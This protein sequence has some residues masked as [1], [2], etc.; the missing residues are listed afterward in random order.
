MNRDILLRTSC[1]LPGLALV[2]AGHL[3]APAR[4]W[5]HENPP[6]PGLLL[7][8]AVGATPIHQGVWPAAT[9]QARAIVHGEP[10]TGTIGPAQA[11]LLNGATDWIEMAPSL[12][13][14]RPFL[15]AR[16]LTVSAWVQLNE[17]HVDGGILGFVQ[18]NGNAETG[19][20]LGYN[21]RSFTFSLA[22]AGADDGDGKLTRIAGQSAVAF[23]RWYYVAATY[24]GARMR[25]YVNGRLEGESD[26]QSGDIRY[27]TRGRLAW[28]A[29][30]DDNELHPMD[31]AILE[32]RVH[33]RVLGDEE[34]AAVARRQAGLLDW[35]ESINKILQFIVA[36]YLQAGGS[37][38]M[39]VMAETSQPAT[40]VVEYG[41]RQPL[42]QRVTNAEPQAIQTITLSGLKPFARYFYR[43]T[44]ADAQTNVARSDIL[45]FQTF[46]PPATTWAFGI[47]GDTQRNPDVTRRCAEGIFALRPNVVIHC[48]DVVDDGHAKQQWV[49]D[50]FAPSAALLAH[51]PVHPVIGNHEKNSHWYYDYFHLP[52]PEYY[53]TFM[54]GNAQFF[55][56][57]SN[58]D[59]GPGSEQYRWLDQALGRSRATWKFTAHHHPC[60]SSDENDYGDQWKAKAG[61]HFTY[62]D[63]NVQRL[64]PLYEKHG[65]DVAWAGHVHSYERT[66]PMLGLSINQKK[67]VRYIVT[68]GGGG[69]LEQAGPQRSWFTAHVA[70][71]YHYCFVAVQDRTIQFKAY[72]ADGRL[73]D[74]FELVKP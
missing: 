32:A 13:S 65:V 20:M 72:D 70:R 33:R 34:I 40:M 43:V 58:K 73:F 39:T 3:S 42:R 18:D 7:H 11:L 5:A 6:D 68:G 38:T 21:R 36:P 53:Y 55:M 12:E 41:E 22:S 52:A 10:V 69:P 24:D 62:G 31:G 27:P 2:L 23:D 54:I 57:D 60:F 26:A 29:Y 67:G 37:T 61:T 47:L 8:F 49:N 17:T 4:T 71:G 74:S 15:P 46:P 50:L 44:C 14:A 35:R 9:G 19:W 56:L 59:C 48:G 28:G 66:W 30:V 63:T 25:L 51:V 64:V 45:T 1:W 16:E